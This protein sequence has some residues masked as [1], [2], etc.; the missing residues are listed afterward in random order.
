MPFMKRLLL[1]AA[2]VFAGYFMMGKMQRNKT[3]KQVQ[4]AP[5]K[6]VNTLQQD[7]QKAQA[8]RDQANEIIRSGSK[9]IEKNI[10]QAGVP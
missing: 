8:A 10:S 1:I 5:V 4:E 6:Y 2:L 9:E 3:I 7:M